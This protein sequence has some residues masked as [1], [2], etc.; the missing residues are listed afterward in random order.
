[1]Y[2]VAGGLDVNHL[3]GMFEDVLCITKLKR[4]RKTA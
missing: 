2:Q 3:T 1:M 4:R